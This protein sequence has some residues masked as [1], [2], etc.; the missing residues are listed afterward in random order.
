MCSVPAA[1]LFA[2]LRVRTP[3]ADGGPSIEFE[4]HFMPG[5]DELLGRGCCSL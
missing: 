3:L 4:R 5:G 1:D 2:D